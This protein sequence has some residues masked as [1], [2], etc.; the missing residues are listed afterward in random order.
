MKKYISIVLI[1][2]LLLSIPSPVMA[3]E[4]V[5][6]L[7]VTLVAKEKDNDFVPISILNWGIDGSNGEVINEIPL[8]L[9]DSIPEGGTSIPDNIKNIIEEMNLK[10]IL[11]PTHNNNELSCVEFINPEWK[12]STNPLILLA[13]S[14]EMI[15]F[16]F[17]SALPFLMTQNIDDIN[18]NDFDF[19]NTPL[20]K[21]T[22][23][24]YLVFDRDGIDKINELLSDEEKFKET[25]ELILNYKI[26]TALVN[27]GLNEFNLEIISNLKKLYK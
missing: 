17:T 16:S 27:L 15:G 11:T 20:L 19:G 21:D 14:K 3:G 24:N 9:I 8:K 26:E 1:F 13:G 12:H 2:A 5:K 25:I 23:D 4:V 6:S 7:E 22:A 18:L 10:S